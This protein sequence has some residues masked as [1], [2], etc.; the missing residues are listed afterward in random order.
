MPFHHRVVAAYNTVLSMQTGPATARA[1][2]GTS[3]VKLLALA[4]L[5]AFGF[6]FVLP[7][8]LVRLLDRTEFSLYKQSFLLVSTATTILPFGWGASLFYFFPREPSRR[9]QVLANTFAYHLLVACAAGAALTLFPSVLGGL[10]GWELLVEHRHLLAAVIALN[11]VSGLLESAVIAGADVMSGSAFIVAAQASRS[12]LLAGAVIWSPR[13]EAL[14]WAAILQGVLQSFVMIWY[15]QKRFSGWWERLCLG[16]AREQA[17]YA[18][19][20]GLASL[21][22]PIQAEFH[23]YVVAHGVPAPVYAMYAVGCF[24]VPLVGIL[25][26]SLFTILSR[27]MSDLSAQGKRQEMGEL[28]LSATRK[29][30]LVYMPVC[31]LLLVCGQRFLTVL[32]TDEYNSSWPVFAI[33][34]GLLPLAVLITE[35]FLRANDRTMRISTAVRLAFTAAL[36]CCLPFSLDKFGLTGPIAAVLLFTALER[37]TTTVVVA[38]VANITFYEFVTRTDLARTIVAAAS[39]AAGAA[40]VQHIL[41][42][43]RDILVLVVCALTFLPFYVVSLVLTGSLKVDELFEVLRLCRRRMA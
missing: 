4:K 39:A 23:L 12:V 19:P 32:F 16:A 20:L 36:V 38:R 29:L 17:R 34:L 40:V 15:F 30:A 2:S 31:A 37:V 26:E 5:V 28:F 6:S 10:F 8:L 11:L 9:P 27:R 18:I 14:L 35:P 42:D 41:R 1:R 22:L 24:Q 33:N 13:I 7:L 25:R 43:C 21:A 3:E